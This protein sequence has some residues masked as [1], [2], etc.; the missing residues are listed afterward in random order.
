MRGTEGSAGSVQ[1]VYTHATRHCSQQLSS[2]CTGG[3]QDVLI[4]V[5]CSHRLRRQEP[6]TGQTSAHLVDRVMAH[7]ASPRL[8]LTWGARSRLQGSCLQT[9]AVHCRSRGCSRWLTARPPAHE[10]TRLT[11]MAGTAC[12]PASAHQLSQLYLA[13]GGKRSTLSLALPS[14]SRGVH[15][16]AELARGSYA[17]SRHVH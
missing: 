10:V 17:A 6:H 1:Q 9:A 8:V 3:L 4:C 11:E 14:P 5:G 7:S 12:V 15:W 13:C 16:A 2:A